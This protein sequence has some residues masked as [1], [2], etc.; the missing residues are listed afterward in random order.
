MIT[1]CICDD[2]NASRLETKL[3]LSTYK[4]VVIIAELSNGNDLLA[5]LNKGIKPDIII[6]DIQMPN[7]N[8]YEV[9]HK[10][11]QRYPKQNILCYS[12]HLNKNIILKVLLNGAKGYLPKATGAKQLIKAIEQI[13]SQK[14]ISTNEWI[15]QEILNEYDDYKRLEHVNASV[16]DITHRETEI[17]RKLNEGL[18]Y[19]EIAYLLNISEH[20][21]KTHCENIYKKL[22]VN[23]KRDAIKIAVNHALIP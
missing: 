6:L 13:T 17:L 16:L 14:S 2:F 10:I 18:T 9:C 12:G 1:V 22:Q 15:T 5:E 23:S 8:G 11:K 4:H 21:V 3:L 7:M 19:A 20:T